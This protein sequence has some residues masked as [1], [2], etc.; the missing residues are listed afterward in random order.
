MA[1]VSSKGAV[2][3]KAAVTKTATKVKA[4]PK[5]LQL[6]AAQ[7]KAYSSA[8]SSNLSAQIL[9]LA[10]ARYR[11]YRLN[12]ALTTI[13]KYRVAQRSA[14]AAAIA[15][16]ATHQSAVQAHDGHQNAAL[17]AR[18]NA[19]NYRHQTLL[20]RKQFAQAGEKKYMS[21]AIARTVDTVQAKAHEESV[22]AAAARVR[23]AAAKSV[24]ATKKVYP[25]SKKPLNAAANAAGLK[26]AMAPSL[27]AGAAKQKKATAAKAHAAASKTAKA[28]AKSSAQATAAAKSASKN[29]V[30][31]KG[32]TAGNPDLHIPFSILPQGWLGDPAVPTCVPVAIAN[33]LLFMAG[34]RMDDEYLARFVFACGYNPSISHALKVLKELTRARG[35]LGYDDKAKYELCEYAEVPGKYAHSQGLVVGYES[36]YG[37]HAALSLGNGT[38]VSWGQEIPEDAP[39]EEAWMIDWAARRA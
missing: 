21:K 10:T 32:R 24:T 39:I 34:T 5:G 26:A 36:S 19:D 17:Q 13:G 33:H 29:A 12:A 16:Y 18:I 11:K 1:A 15:A 27:V 37:P 30:T 7:W 22:I 6:S 23:A 31:A 28:T 8:Y 38:V 9:K 3:K 2:A 14:Q 4:A 35:G 25:K 20:G